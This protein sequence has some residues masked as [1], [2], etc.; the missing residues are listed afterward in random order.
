MGGNENPKA[1]ENI[2]NLTVIEASGN[3]RN[4]NKDKITA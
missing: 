2:T 3:C 1:I 4:Y